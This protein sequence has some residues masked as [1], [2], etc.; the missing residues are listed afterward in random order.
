MRHSGKIIKAKK[1]ITDK[2]KIEN[3][4]KLRISIEKFVS[5]D[6]VAK[7]LENLRK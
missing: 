3:P 2:E 7:Q 6:N 4:K 5:R 1:I